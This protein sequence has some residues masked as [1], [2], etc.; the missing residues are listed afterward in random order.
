MANH[1][2]SLPK[3]AA[4]A[5]SL[6]ATGMT[7]K[8][9]AEQLELPPSRIQQWAKRED[10]KQLYRQ[11]LEGAGLRQ[12]ARAINVLETQMESK[13]D[14]LAQN[15][16]RD[17]A[18]RFEKAVAG[19]ENNRITVTLAGMPELGTPDNEETVDEQ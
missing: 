17:L 8:Q 1:K 4:E 14:W 13:N 19:I 7:Y 10:F 11:I 6:L 16:A 2:R 3:K 12:Y 18:N 9:I 15:A 5:A